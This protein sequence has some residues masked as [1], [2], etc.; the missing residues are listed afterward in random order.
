[1]TTLE[2]TLDSLAAQAT[3][4]WVA[5]VSELGGN[6]P[7]VIELAKAA[8]ALRSAVNTL[9]SNL[10]PMDCFS[11]GG[12]WHIMTTPVTPAQWFVPLCGAE[13]DMDA[14]VRHSNRRAPSCPECI[15]LYKEEKARSR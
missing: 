4:T 13:V 3:S 12:D 6:H 8:T 10:E 5:L 2:T 11:Q 1:M 14:Q 15:R 7:V 9:S